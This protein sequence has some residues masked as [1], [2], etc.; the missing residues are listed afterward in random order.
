MIERC[1][2]YPDSEVRIS[3]LWKARVPND[4][5]SAASPQPLSEERITEIFAADLWHAASMHRASA[6]PLTD[7]HWV[8]V[9]HATYYPPVVVAD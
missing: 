2:T 8:D 6:S 9:V 7:E 5:R 4:D 3:I 1:A